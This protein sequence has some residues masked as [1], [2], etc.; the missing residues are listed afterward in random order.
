MEYN[1][2]HDWILK[3]I[4][5]GGKMLEFGSGEGTKRFTEVFHVTS[6]EHDLKYVSLAEKSNYIHAPIVKNW[7]DVTKLQGL[8]NN[9]YDVIL[10]DG[11]PGTIGRNGLLM[12][13][14]LFD[15]NTVIVV[16]DVNR[17]SEMEMFQKLVMKLKA[18][19]LKIFKGVNR[20]FAVI[21]NQKILI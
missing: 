15:W 10:I 8:R 14:H 11:P 17:A 6:I 5:K 18:T 19:D 20:S 3:N 7:Y 2:F 9:H 13:L 16:D 21:Y 12:N 1:T 4:P